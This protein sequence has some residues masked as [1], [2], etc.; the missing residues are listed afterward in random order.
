MPAQITIVRISRMGT[1]IQYIAKKLD[2]NGHICISDLSRQVYTLQRAGNEVSDVHDL[3]HTCRHCFKLFVLQV[4]KAGVNR[5]GKN[6]TPPF[7][8]NLGGLWYE[9]V[10]E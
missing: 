9:R 7:S 5:P 6:L 2:N 3:T 8:C 4:K 10:R 1:G